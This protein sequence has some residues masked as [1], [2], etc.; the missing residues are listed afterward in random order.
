MRPWRSTRTEPRAQATRRATR[1]APTKMLRAGGLELVLRVE[2]DKFTQAGTPTRLCCKL[3]LQRLGSLHASHRPALLHRGAR[4]PR[5]AAAS[6]R[7]PP[8]A[9]DARSLSR[10]AR[11]D[12]PLAH[13][14]R[15]TLEGFLADSTAGRLG[16][17]NIDIDR[18]FIRRLL[19]QLQPIL[20]AFLARRHPRLTP[21]AAG[22]LAHDP[23]GL[24]LLATIGLGR[25]V[26]RRV[27]EHRRQTRRPPGRR[28]ASGSSLRAQPAYLGLPGSVDFSSPRVVQS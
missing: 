18:A 6:A 4:A 19:D 7:P 16:F 17:E 22:P 10:G 11:H 5:P 13:R 2:R 3:E 8:R 14:Q 28:R 26:A 23:H 1:R 21:H 25:H 15:H 12:A 9:S 27:A 24:R 20:D